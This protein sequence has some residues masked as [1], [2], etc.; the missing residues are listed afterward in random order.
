VSVERTAPGLIVNA[1]DLA[2]HPS[3]N[4]GI[5]SAYRNGIVTSATMLMTTPYLA[6]TIRSVVRTET[7]PIGI[8]LSLTLGTPAA[9]RRDV[10]DLVDARGDFAWSSRR[11][12]LCSFAGETERRLLAQIRREFEAQLGLARDHGL[13]PTHAD[14]HQHVHM[15][16]AIFAVLEELLPRFGIGRLR[17]SREALSARGLAGLLRQGKAINLAK[18]A[19]L[20]WLSMRLRPRL[21]TPDGFFGVLF[22]GVMTKRAIMQ[23]IAGLSRDRS[24]EIC[25]HPGFPAAAG[26]AYPRSYENDFISSAGRQREHDILVDAEMAELVRRH[27]LVLRSFDDRAKISPAHR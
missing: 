17:C 27:Q 25:V 3:I 6:E 12:L 19:L 2:I 24:L 22:S 4:A 26:A 14:S 5:V 18:I 16:P 23:A 7:L 21:A 15:N 20:R 13:R 8:H 1:D 10:P 9:A 11:L